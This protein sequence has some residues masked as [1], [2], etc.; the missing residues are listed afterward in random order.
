[1][2]VDVCFALTALSLC[3]VRFNELLRFS[4]NISVAIMERPPVE[5]VLALVALECVIAAADGPEPICEA[6]E[7]VPMSVDPAVA[8]PV[9]LSLPLFKQQ[10][11]YTCGPASMTS[12]LQGLGFANVTEAALAIEMK[13]DSKYGTLFEEMEGPLLRR[14]VA[15]NSHQDMTLDELRSVLLSGGVVIVLY[16]AWPELSTDVDWPIMWRDGHYSVVVGM[17]ESRVYLMDPYQAEGMY[18]WIPHEEFLQRWHHT[19]GDP[20]VGSPIVRGGTT[21]YSSSRRSFQRIVIPQNVARTV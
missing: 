14:G 13:T 2:A 17:D 1:M 21:L 8:Q 18:G 15:A 5:L 9:F 19:N 4:N 6:V 11:E 7:D 3:L 16:Q 10:T 20:A 12:V